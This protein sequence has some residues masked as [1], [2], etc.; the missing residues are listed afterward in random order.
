MTDKAETKA[1]ILADIEKRILFY[2]KSCESDPIFWQ[3]VLDATWRHHDEVSA[4]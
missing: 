2:Q 4:W 1:K 3:P